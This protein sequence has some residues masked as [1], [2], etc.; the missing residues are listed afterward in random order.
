MNTKELDKAAIEKELLIKTKTL[1][2]SLASL[3]NS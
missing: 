3:P 1:C 2:E